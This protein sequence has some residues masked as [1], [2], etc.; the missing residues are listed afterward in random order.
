ML[1]TITHPENICQ[2][3]KSVSSLTQYALLLQ[4]SSTAGP[5]IHLPDTSLLDS[6][7]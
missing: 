1:H 2:L 6:S 4:S 7:Q 5:Y 3:D